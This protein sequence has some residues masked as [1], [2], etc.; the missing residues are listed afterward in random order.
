MSGTVKIIANVVAHLELLLVCV[1]ASVPMS[2]A[3]TIVATFV[4]HFRYP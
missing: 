1:L 3:F 2:G 4:F